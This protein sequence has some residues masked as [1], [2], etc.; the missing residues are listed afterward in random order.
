MANEQKAEVIILEEYTTAEELPQA[1]IEL[2]EYYK[3]IGCNLTNGTPGGDGFIKG[4]KMLEE[5]KRKLSLVL[6][7]KPKSDEHKKAMSLAAKRRWSQ[8]K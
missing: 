2:I 4:R 5:T 1:E 7:G 3:Y 6:S 8:G